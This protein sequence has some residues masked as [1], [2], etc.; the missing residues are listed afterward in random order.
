[1]TPSDLRKFTR[2]PKQ[3]FIDQIFASY[4]F[5]DITCVDAYLREFGN[6]NLMFQ[7]D[8]P[9][10]TSLYP[11]VQGKIAETLGHRDRETQENV[12]FRTAERVYG[13]E[14]YRAPKQ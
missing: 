14:V 1:M 9:H 3:M 7:T 5:E 2:T 12:L 4:W 8:F 13:T 6:R 11:N 10:P